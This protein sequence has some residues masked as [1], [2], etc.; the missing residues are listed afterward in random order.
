[1]QNQTHVKT[2]FKFIQRQKLANQKKIILKDKII[3]ILFIFNYKSTKDI[4]KI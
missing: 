3:K 2:R 1:M 4:Y